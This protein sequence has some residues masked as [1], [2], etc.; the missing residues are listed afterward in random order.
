MN[1]TGLL[2][3]LGILGE[4][5]LGLPFYFV[6]VGGLSILA[7]TILLGVAV[8]QMKLNSQIGAMMFNPY[9]LMTLL[10][11]FL[12]VLAAVDASAASLNL[13]PWFNGLRWLRV[14]F[15]TLGVLTEVIFGLLAALVAA[16]SGQP[17]PKTRWDIWLTLNAGLLTLIVG[18]PLANGALM[19][20]GGTL[21]FIAATLLMKQLSDLR[22][23]ASASNV[24]TG[25][26]RTPAL[27]GGA[28]EFYIA[29]LSYLLLGIFVGTG[30]WI[31]WPQLF[32]IKV[33]IEVHIH[34]N[35]WGF[36]SLVFA[37]LLVDLY[38]GFAKRQLAWPR[39]ITPIFWMMTTGALLLVI[40]PWVKNELFS[41]PGIILHLS[42]T[43]WL[44][45]NVITPLKGER[46]AWG[47]GLWHL[48]TSYVWIIA[49]VLVAPL[50]LLKVPGFPG[51][52]IEQ[53][54]PQALIYGWVM[55][56]G[57]AL[58]PYL[59]TRGFLPEQSAKLGGSW[60][61]LITAHL[62][63]VFLW[64]SIFVTDYQAVLHGTAYA[65]WVVSIVP[66]VI[67]LWRIARAGLNRVESAPTFSDGPSAESAS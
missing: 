52:G 12:A 42:A 2:M 11:A 19:L 33:P 15:I 14:H 35:N 59:F 23:V 49:P 1:R 16:R 17:R 37:G 8:V 57:F 27:A 10:Y 45:A 53:N 62:G 66:I 4:V 30:L 51:A 3:P 9:F 32:Q 65:L 34:A 40:G 55:Q 46:G 29:G 43:G 56:F 36:M 61:S 38:P 18:V 67:D 22:P 50:I 39:S 63:G 60:F 20:A 25:T 7:A 58:I 54:A 47:P 44:L 26:G 41:V 6:L 64:V 28:R 13:L 5:Y 31:G 24:P 21:I 48:V